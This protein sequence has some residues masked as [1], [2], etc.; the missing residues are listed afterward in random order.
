MP[1]DTSLIAD[2]ADTTRVVLRVTDEF[3]AIRPFANDAIKFE[4]EGP[5]EIIGDNPFAVGGRNRG[6]LDS[7]Q[8]AGRNGPA[9][10][11]ASGVGQAAGGV[12]DC[13]GRSGGGVAAF[14]GRRV[15]AVVLEP[16]SGERMKPRAQARGRLAK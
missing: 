8:G 3:D 2:G 10:S 11:D 13:R 9:D 1:D 6:D 14:V 4:L 12:C 16:R 15:S 7:S 5:A